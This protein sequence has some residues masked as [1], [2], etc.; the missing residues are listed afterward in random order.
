MHFNFGFSAVQVLWTLVFA[1]LLVL[2][3]VLLGRERARR[4]PWFTASIAAMALGLLASRLLYG[5]LPSI[6]MNAIMIVLGDVEALL[7]LLV[8]VEL[9]RR[10]FAGAS[11]RN[12]VVGTVGLVVIAGGI[13]AAWRPWVP[14]EKLIANPHVAALN[15]MLAVAA[16]SDTLLVATGLEK[17]NVLVCLL[18][19]ELAI[20]VVVFGRRYHAGWRSHSQ[21]ILI[22]LFSFAVAWLTVQGVWQMMT[23]AAHIQN[24]A[25]YEHILGIGDKLLNAERTVYFCVLLWW[26]ACLWIDEPGAKAEGGAAA[27]TAAAASDSPEN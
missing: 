15:V 25:Q 4:F 27:E 2:L 17:G 22:G 16:P 3:V 21:Q 10:A 11:R 12:W 8:L 19:V 7:G 20:L 26:I 5:R 14:W 18:T 6:A 24:R 9:A 23:R 1:A 13:V